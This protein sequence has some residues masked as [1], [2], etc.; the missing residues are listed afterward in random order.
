MAK[1]Y[2][3][4]D[5]HLFCKR[6][7]GERY[8]DEL[9]AVATAADTIVLGG[10]I[11]DFPWTDRISVERSVEEATLCLAQLCDTAPNC[12]FHYLLGNHDFHQSFIDQLGNLSSDHENFAWQPFHLR[13]RN[14]VFLH[15]DVAD[16][17]STPAELEHSRSR[18]KQATKKGPTMNLMYDLVVRANVHRAVCSVLYRNRRVTRNILTYLESIYA[19]P[20]TGVEQVYFGHTHIP[21]SHFRSGGVTFHNGGAPIH[22]LEFQ[23]LEMVI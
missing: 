2:F 19:G 16:G 12:Q 5:L 1:S 20:S 23:F 8:W 22:G 7:Y 3:I 10:D 6:S 17:H 4:S 21:I 18:W 11:F 9:T 14:T 15:G 13:L